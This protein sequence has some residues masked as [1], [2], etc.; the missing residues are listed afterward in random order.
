MT[1]TPKAARQGSNPSKRDPY[2]AVTDRIVA[3]LE[4]GVAPW[5][6]P[7][8]SLGAAGALRNAVSDRAYNGINVLLLALEPYTDPR[9]VTFKQARQ[10]GGHVRKGEHGTQIVF[11]KMLKRSVEGEPDKTFPMLRLYTVFNVAQCEELELAELSTDPLPEPE[12]DGACERFVTGTGADVRYGRGQAFYDR[13]GDFIGLP[14]RSAFKDAGALYATAFHELTHWTGSTDRLDR[15]KGK[16]FG[17]DAYAFE[18][19]VAELGSAFLCQRFQVDGTLQHTAY[20][21]NWRKALKGDSRFIF[22]AAS[23][24]RKACE[25]MYE[26]AGIGGKILEPKPVAA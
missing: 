1:S 20:L 12:R 16:R 18:E 17:D 22:S 15:T 4:K 6:R 5:V 26:Q 19:L 9:Y 13:I 11:W 14:D 7:W 25:W 24:A 21:A 23:Y 3:A 8:R 2:Q 10:L